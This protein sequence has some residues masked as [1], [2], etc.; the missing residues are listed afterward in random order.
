MNPLKPVYIDGDYDMPL[1]PQCKLPVDEEE[2]GECCSVCGQ[3]LDWSD[4][5]AE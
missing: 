4:N 1:C 3:E 5:D 2:E